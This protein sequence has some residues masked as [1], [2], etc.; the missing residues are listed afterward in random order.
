MALT[1]VASRWNLGAYNNAVAMAI[2]MLK[3]TLVV[4]FFM[5]VKYGSKLTWLWAGIGFIWFL[6]MFGILMDYGT[7]QWIPIKGWEALPQ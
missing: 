3:A 1:I 5:Q 7:R 4:W 6:L 2:A